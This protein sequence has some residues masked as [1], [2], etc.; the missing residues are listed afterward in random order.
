MEGGGISLGEAI[1]DD[2]LMNVVKSLTDVMTQEIR[3]LKQVGERK[4]EG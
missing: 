1:E 2:Q 3:R 4:S